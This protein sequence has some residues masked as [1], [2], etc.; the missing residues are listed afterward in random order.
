MEYERATLAKTLPASVLFVVANGLG[1]ERLFLEH[2]ILFSDRRLLALVLN[3]NEHDES[4]FVSKLKEHNVECDPKVINSEV[5]IKDR[6]SIY[7]EG[8]VQFC[9]SRV[10]LVDLLQ[11]RIPTD[12][13][14]AIFVYRAHQT[15][16][17][18]QD[19]FILRLYRE[20]KPDGTV[21][22]FTD[23]PNSLSSLGQLQRLVD[24]LYI[25]HVELMPRFSSIIESELNRY[26]LKTAIFSVDVPTPLRRVHRTIIEFI[27][28]CVRDLRT[29][30]T[31]GKQ[32]DEQNE[33]M[34][35]VPW[36]AT[37]LEKRLHDR[38]GHISEKQQRLLNDVASLREI[39]QL[40]ENMD[41]A[42]VLS[43]LQVLKNDRT[44]LE[45]H[46]GWLLSPSF[47]RIMED[48][49]TI[50]GVTNGKADYKKFATPAKWTVLSEILREIKMLPVEK[51]DRGNDSP[52][53]L[54]IT[55]SEDLSRQVTDVVRYGINK[56]KWMTWR[57]LGYKSTQ[58]MPEDEP[59][60]D[61]DT[62][63]QLMRSSV[64][65]ES[66]SE[67]IANV[68]KTQ[69]TTARA[70]QK[71]RKHAEELSGFSSDHRVQTNL[72]QFGI[73]QYKRRKSGNEA[74]TSQETTEWEVKEE[75]E[76]I[77]EITK[78]IG[79]LEAELVVSTTRERERYTLLKLLETKK[80]RA[81]VLYTMSLQTLRQIEI[82]RSTNPNRSLHVYWL[83]YT[84]S[85]E[86]SRYLESINRET[87]SFELLIREQGTLLISRE[88]NVD[89]EDAP[90]LKISTRDGGGAR[91][92]GAVDP[93]DQ[94]DPEE[95][96]E[97][98][99]IIVDM[100]E[101]NS[102]LPTV[103][104]TKGYNVV[105]TTIEI[106]D[107]ILS[108]NIAIERKALDDLT[109]SLQSGRVFKQIEQMLEHYDCTVLLI[110]SN[111]KFETKI[112]NGGPFQGELSRHC[113]EIRSIFCSLI[114]ANPK[115]RCV[116]TISPTNSAEFFSEL[117][118]SAP[119]PDVD[120]AISLKA[121]QVEC[122]SQ[123][124]TDSEAS[125][126][127]KAKKGK[128]WKPNPTVIRTLTQ[129]FGIKA[130]EAHNLLANSSIKTLADLFSLNITA[131]HLSDF[132]P[133]TSADFI[134]DLSTFNF[135]RK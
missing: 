135:G 29:C 107:Y 82:Y 6:Q 41:V 17:A 94:M 128:K 120:R 38:R 43:R 54:V 47:N 89:R 70:A 75:M 111:R 22:A 68:Q 65:G 57:Q 114:W 5:S 27:K 59:L 93:R 3:T 33:E 50:A 28:V 46:S 24:R 21:K 131:S 74:S 69:K 116:W 124:L 64:D 129:I 104:Y 97:R 90:R 121:D 10:L 39:L 108:P 51:K 53:V 84:E 100:R 127:T 133:S 119:E 125:T 112:V 19:S 118:L 52:S 123:E 58:E 99:K 11:N 37:R 16:N 48:L 80:P 15:L 32:T 61:P 103:L 40:S 4:Y 55:S 96:L 13:I 31:S 56:M 101:F 91:R 122:S 88:F 87:M 76:E 36:A 78:N 25:R 12:R 2:L 49:L 126:S 102:E 86:E 8:G 109:Q 113:R 20:K 14:A 30:S 23:F 73:L 110:E 81:I 18:F 79:D 115:M 117:K 9:S 7:L 45:E 1:L 34:I 83:Q 42:T 72:I 98:P 95:E 92:D 35:H 130:S 71:R 106:G 44:V 63:S 105:A 62:I 132:I 66:K 77:E 85:T 67:V 60:W 26:Q 134:K